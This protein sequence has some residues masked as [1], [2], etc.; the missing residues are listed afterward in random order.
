MWG[1]LFFV[2]TV[3]GVFSVVLVRFWGGVL[4]WFCVMCFCFWGFGVGGWDG[5]GTI[6]WGF[7]RFERFKR[8]SVASERSSGVWLVCVGN[9]LGVAN[10]SIS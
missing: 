7:E 9:T 1:G 5:V 6:V 4:G 10:A 3:G 8:A 2:G